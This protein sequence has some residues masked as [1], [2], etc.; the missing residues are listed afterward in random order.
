MTLC[1]IWFAG[2]VFLFNHTFNYLMKSK[3]LALNLQFLTQPPT[4]V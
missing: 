1:Y 2:S 3:K 4:F